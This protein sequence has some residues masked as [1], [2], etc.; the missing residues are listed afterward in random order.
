MFTAQFFL[1]GPWT[2]GTVSPLQNLSYL[3]WREARVL[4]SP[5]QSPLVPGL[6]HPSARGK[7]GSDHQGG[8]PCSGCI[9]FPGTTLHRTIRKTMT[10]G[11]GGA[12]ASKLDKIRIIENM[13][14]HLEGR[15]Q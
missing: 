14:K 6:G 13:R 3:R 9:W 7:R 8:C 11:G 4:C 2:V 1:P 12:G 15:T 10:S 5:W